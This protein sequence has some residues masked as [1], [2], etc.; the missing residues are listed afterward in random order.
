MK[1]RKRKSCCKKKIISNV[2]RKKTTNVTYFPHGVANTFIR[3]L[4]NY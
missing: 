1:A 3:A 4:T 2:K